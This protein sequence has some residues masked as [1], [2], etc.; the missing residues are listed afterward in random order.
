[1]WIW[2][3]VKN[4][5]GVI[6]LFI[7]VA[8]FSC[9]AP[10]V[11]P[12]DPNNPDYQY[13]TIDGFIR[14]AAS[15]NQVMSGVKVTWRNQSLVVTTDSNGYYKISDVPRK[16]GFIV[17]EK[18]G[19]YK[20]SIMVQFNN[21]S[22]IRLDDRYL[23]LIPALVSTIDGYVKTAASPNQVMSGVKVTWRNQGFVAITDANGY[24]KIPDV[25]KSNGYIVFE[26]DKY[27]KDSS[28]VLFDDQYSSSK[29]VDKS[30]VLS[31][32][33]ISTIDGY[34]KTVASPNQA[35]S[36]VKVTWG[37]QNLV[38]L[39]DAYGYYKIP[40]VTKNN[41]YITFEKDGYA[42]ESLW[43]Q[44]NDQYSSYKRIEDSFLNTIPILNNI[45]IYTIVENTYTTAN[46]RVA[47]RA[48]VTDIEDNVDSVFVQCSPLGFYRQLKYN[49]STKYYE[50]TFSE[51]DL[52]IQ[53]MEIAVGQDFYIYA[54]DKQ[55]GWFK[56]GSSNIKRIIKDEVIPV[57]P[58]NKQVVGSKPTLKWKRFLPGFNFTYKVQIYTDALIPV[59]KWEK[60]GI[61]K[62]DIQLIT[63][64]SLSAGEYYWV[65]WSIDDYQNSGIS[66]PVSFIVQ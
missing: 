19:Y 57:S 58:L 54:K 12:L 14:T 52:N 63:D 37:N 10:H 18:D 61:S 39:T 59:L 4:F 53:S 48:L 49:S 28:Y 44:F 66:K 35:I 6:V 30:L 38:T 32:V 41:G 2:P 29:R 20:D 40:D 45:L 9:D 50:N 21:Q 42:K 25:A 24:Y 3:N 55:K 56:I 23:N 5:R 27:V 51:S 15:P 26:K 13:S 1:M 46:L 8:L 64:I 17:F 60:S 31:Q 34:V 16:N 43:V 11:N 33:Y 7:V 36:G 22:N 62:S 65:I 47:V